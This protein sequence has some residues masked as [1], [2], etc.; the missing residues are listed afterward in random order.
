M[1]H[2]VYN[3]YA[4]PGDYSDGSYEERFGVIDPTDS[5]R[6]GRDSGLPGT[7]VVHIPNPTLGDY[8]MIPGEASRSLSGGDWTFLDYTWKDAVGDVLLSSVFGAAVGL[9]AGAARRNTF[10]WKPAAIG[11]GVGF[12][13]L[14]A[15]RLIRG[16]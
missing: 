10:A 5:W 4:T 13:S 9:I 12:G 16:L 1:L 2:A 11:A 7:S 15:M 8:G 3:P 6:T 14:A